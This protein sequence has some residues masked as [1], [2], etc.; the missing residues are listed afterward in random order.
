M[1]P[2]TAPSGSIDGRAFDAASSTA[3]LNANG[4]L[5]ISIADYVL[6]C[7][8]LLPPDDALASFP[9][10]VLLLIEEERALPG[11]LR[12]EFPDVQEARAN[13]NLYDAEGNGL[14]VVVRRG[15]IVI[16]AIDA[17]SVRGSF[18]LLETST[19]VSIAGSFDI[20]FCPP[21]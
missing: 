17:A 13:V 18:S 21:E 12:I 11:V 14:S 1:K 16:D 4:D 7:L 9:R 15:E 10:K 8:T 2:G 19:D 20:P 6:S 3:D 5:V